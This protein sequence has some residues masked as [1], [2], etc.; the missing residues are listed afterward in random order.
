MLKP[1]QF[2]GSLSGHKALIV[3]GLY[4]SLFLKHDE[5][6]GARAPHPY[7][8]V[9][10]WDNAFS[11]AQARKGKTH[12]W[13]LEWPE[14]REWSSVIVGHFTVA[15]GDFNMERNIEISKMCLPSQ[16][17]V[18]F[19][20]LTQSA[21]RCTLT[22]VL[23]KTMS[24]SSIRGCDIDDAH[25]KAHSKLLITGC[26]MSPLAENMVLADGWW[27]EYNAEGSVTCIDFSQEAIETAAMRNKTFR[28]MNSNED[29]NISRIHYEVADATELYLKAERQSINSQGRQWEPD[30]PFHAILDK[31]LFDALVL[32]GDGSDKIDECTYTRLGKLSDS[33]H[34][35][36][37]PKGIWLVYSLSG[38]AVVKHALTFHENGNGRLW[39][40]EVHRLSKVY[41]YIATKWQSGAS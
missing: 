37:R 8:C 13:L 31:G 23:K 18:W 34:R 2:L 39:H 33:M 20:W 10:F 9:S 12:D 1:A 15:D 26:G 16:S 21:K 27:S 29:H 4:E 6:P 24:R 38:P 22:S 35:M 14:I 36:L 41:L 32:S 17:T 7:G 19:R 40:V 28:C 30:E 11:A 25:V 3:R 5:L